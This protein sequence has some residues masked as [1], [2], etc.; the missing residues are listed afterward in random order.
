MVTKTYNAMKEVKITKRAHDEIRRSFSSRAQINS[1]RTDPELTEIVDNFAFDKTLQKSEGFVLEK[2]RV[3]CILAAT[4]GCNA[5]NE[6]KLF[7][8]ACLNF[9]VKPRE[10]REIVY[11]A[12]PY[13]GAALLVDYTLLM[14]DIFE[15]RIQLR[16]MKK[17]SSVDWN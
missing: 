17:H 4:I 10:I 1:L 14:N 6:F 3:M 11:M 12:Y 13:V 16:T 2:T 5:I 8:D 9:G 7:V 15:N